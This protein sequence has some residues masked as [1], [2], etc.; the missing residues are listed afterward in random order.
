MN[1]FFH[2]A[3]SPIG[4]GSPHYRVFTIILRHSNTF[5]R[6]PLEERSARPR[7]LYLTTQH[8]CKTDGYALGGI[9]TYNSS[10]RAAAD[11]RL[12]HVATGIGIWVNI[13]WT[14]NFCTPCWPPRT[15]QRMPSCCEI[16]C[17]SHKLSL[18]NVGG[19]SN[20]H[21]QPF[22]IIWIKLHRVAHEMS[23]R[24]IIPLKL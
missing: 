20:S 6:T 2:G 4:P 9:R 17:D 19:N 13:T 8:S 16:Y 23:Y 3:T 1:I 14:R 5:G 12:K 21:S 22:K 24:F 18:V 7:D 15:G 11:P 10:K